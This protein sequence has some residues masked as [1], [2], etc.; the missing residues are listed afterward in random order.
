MMCLVIDLNMK[1]YIERL[2]M[3]FL[4]YKNDVFRLYRNDAQPIFKSQWVTVQITI[5]I[6]DLKVGCVYRPTFILPSCH[7]KSYFD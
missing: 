6:L 7:I 2:K 3:I 4:L 1:W 5:T